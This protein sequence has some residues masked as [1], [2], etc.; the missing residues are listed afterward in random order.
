MYYAKSTGGFYDNQIHATIP[1]D[2][3]E[4]TNEYYQELLAGQASG[5]VIQADNKG[6]PRLVPLPEPTPEEM[7]NQKNAEARSYLASTDWYVVR[8]VET[9][10][11]IPEE[12]RAARE[13][14]RLMVVE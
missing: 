12:I 4:I 8:L 3:V 1:A 11:E 7:Q 9:G 6:F 2:A 5:E 10:V 14:A 13:N